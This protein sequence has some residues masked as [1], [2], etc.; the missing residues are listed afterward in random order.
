MKQARTSLRAW[1]RAGAEDRT[2]IVA[3]VMITG[4]LIAAIVAQPELPAWRMAAV[5]VA[6]SVLLGLNIVIEV[7][8]RGTAA[9]SWQV[10]AYLAAGSVLYLLAF[11]LSDGLAS[12][13]IAMLLFLLVGQAAWSLPLPVTLVYAVV[14][15]TTL[16]VIIGAAAGITL[17]LQAA[18]NFS[19]GIVF[20]VAFVL[21]AKRYEQQ[22]ARAEEERARAEALLA[23]LQA[24][25]AELRAARER[26][27]TM[28][29]VEERVRLARDI[30]DGLGHYLTALNV[31]LQAA[32]RLQLRDPQRAA[33]AIAACREVAQAA[34][35][36]VRRSVAAMQPSPLDGRSLDVAIEQLV[37]DFGRATA[38]EAHFEQEGDLPA[39]S[40]TLA[41]TLYRAVQEGLTNARK[42]SDAVHVVVSLARLPHAVRLAVCDDGTGISDS[43]PASGFGLAGLRERVERLG[44]W[45]A[46]GPRPE[47]GFLLE[48]VVPAGPEGDVHHDSHLA[49]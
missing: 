27:L 49:G 33:A 42:H 37:A 34:L 4:A 28:A 31:Q 15:T 19:F 26:E 23:Q 10:A 47:G 24:S 44:G 7:K 14:M 17:A 38:I 39:L 46:A 29:A 16:G 18:L 41:M 2:M 32:E 5:V 9:R 22:T 25:H 12:G 43:L 13:V 8:P 3:I 11:W 21:S 45:L 30:H 48:L 35:D 20:V 40:P 6:L 36:E 1:W